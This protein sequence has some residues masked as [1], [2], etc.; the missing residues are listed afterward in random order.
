MSRCYCCN[1]ILTPQEAC[2]K[3]KYSGE[4]TET[5]R[6]CLKTMDVPVITP[7]RSFNQNDLEDI[8]EVWLKTGVLLNHNDLEEDY[9]NGKVDS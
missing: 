7:H 5:C 3:F 2:T 6:K 8:E 9:D 1:V 4:Y